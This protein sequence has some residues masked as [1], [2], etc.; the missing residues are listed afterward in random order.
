M[1]TRAMPALKAMMSKV[2]GVV[3]HCI[4]QDGLCGVCVS[5]LTECV[6]DF[7]IVHNCLITLASFGQR[8]QIANTWNRCVNQTCSNTLASFYELIQIADAW[9]RI[10][11]H[12]YLDILASCGERLRNATT[13]MFIANLSAL[14]TLTSSGERDQ[15]ASTCPPVV[16]T[17]CLNTLASFNQRFQMGGYMLLYFRLNVSGHPRIIRWEHTHIANTWFSLQSTGVWLP[18]H[19]LVSDSRW[20]VHLVRMMNHKCSN[21]LAWFGDRSEITNTWYWFVIHQCC[22]TLVSFREHIQLQ[23]QYVALQ[24]TGFD[25]LGIIR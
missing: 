6:C 14:N 23:I 17:H 25:Y 9:F 15:M 11:N 7:V 21:A 24:I 18:W 3:L 13:W 10:L 1:K 2:Y 4:R 20:Q 22:H 19:H 16:K 5:H 8:F 12:I